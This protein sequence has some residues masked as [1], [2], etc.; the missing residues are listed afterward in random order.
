VKQLCY[1]LKQWTWL[2]TAAS[3]NINQHFP[4]SNTALNFGF[5]LYTS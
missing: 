2:V 1:S 3:V 4:N 5:L